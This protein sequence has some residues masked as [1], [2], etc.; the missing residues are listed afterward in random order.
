[1]DGLRGGR[2]MIDFRED[3]SSLLVSGARGGGV[4]VAEVE[5][6]EGCSMASGVKLVGWSV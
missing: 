5:G 4:L 2:S 6:R 3:R 1:M